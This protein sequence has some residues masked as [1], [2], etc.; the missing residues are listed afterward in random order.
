M[1]E[2]GS[3]SLHT[4]RNRARALARPSAIRLRRSY[5]QAVLT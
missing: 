3:Q 1:R 2:A 5:D 4:D